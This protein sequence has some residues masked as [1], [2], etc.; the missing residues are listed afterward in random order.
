MASFRLSS[1][2]DPVPHPSCRFRWF[3]RHLILLTLAH[4]SGE[5]KEEAK[6]LHD[7]TVGLECVL[8]IV[9]LLSLFTRLVLVLG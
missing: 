6:R 8:I 2:L 9:E 3:S 7:F 4:P 5:W 1:D